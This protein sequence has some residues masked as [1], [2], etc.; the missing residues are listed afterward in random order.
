M[1][2]LFPGSELRARRK[3]LGLSFKDVHKK[4]HVPITHLRALEDGHFDVLPEPAYVRGFVQSYCAA[5]GMDAEPFLLRL[6][7]KKVRH[8]G[9]P[10]AS[11]KSRG[12]PGWLTEA[13][14]WGSISLLLLFSWFT[15]SIVIRPW[16]ESNRPPVEAGELDIA[17]PRHFDDEF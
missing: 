2:N 17:P 5:L 10:Y 6:P 15:Y 7:A 3:A 13:M 4:I 1:S 8:A 14:A 12:Q 11:L 9:G 16:A